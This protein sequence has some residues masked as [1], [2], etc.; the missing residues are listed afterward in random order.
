MDNQ[1]RLSLAPSDNINNITHPFATSRSLP[2]TNAQIASRTPI[3][4]EG[5]LSLY[6]EEL[7]DSIEKRLQENLDGYLF[8]PVEDAPGMYE[9]QQI[10]HI[11]QALYSEAA[12]RGL[13]PP[14][15]SQESLTTP[16]DRV[17]KGCWRTLRVLAYLNCTLEDLWVFAHHASG[18]YI[19]DRLPLASRKDSKDLWDIAPSADRKWLERKGS[20]G[21]R[22]YEAMFTMDPFIFQENQENVRPDRRTPIPII[23]REEIGQGS[24]ATVYECHIAKGGWQN[25]WSGNDRELNTAPKKLAQKVY[26]GWHKADRNSKLQKELEVFKRIK[27]APTT[28]KNVVSCLGSF[29]DEYD[30][31][32]FFEPAD[33]DNPSL[34]ILMQNAKGMERGSLKTFLKSAAGLAA[35][36]DYLHCH[37]EV[38]GLSIRIYHND[39]RPVNIL[40]F[41]DEWKVAD[42]GLSKIK[43]IGN[44]NASPAVHG[45]AVNAKGGSSDYESP[46]GTL[47]TD[48]DNWSLACILV[49]AITYKLDGPDGIEEFWEARQKHGEGKFWTEG[50]HQTREL[51]PAVADWVQQLK[52]RAR[53]WDQEICDAVSAILEYI[54]REVLVIDRSKRNGTAKSMSVELYKAADLL[55]DSEP[56]RPYKGDDMGSLTESRGSVDPTARASDQF[57]RLSTEYSGQQPEITRSRGWFSASRTS[58]RGQ[59]KFGA[60][61]AVETGNDSSVSGSRHSR[62]SS[63]SRYSGIFSSPVEPTTP[64]PRP[65]SESGE[66]SR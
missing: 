4:P 64:S 35:G 47:S 48:S 44:S 58:R 63:K 3:Y 7:C 40:I 66:P 24:S 38:D 33:R 18:L 34:E 9:E 55:K 59:P 29:E 2:R 16:V 37:I 32:L 13:A 36:L 60:N 65:A 1:P 19:D 10:R 12:R 43:E 6:V 61:L 45:S 20:L 5:S 8:L 62:N 28:H 53:A 23:H 30:V 21:S 41:G 49:V 39:F 42:L 14:V 52:T 22:F 51:N 17:F 57:S 11:I 50:V 46:D 54:L 26:K 15:A 31:S 27:A 56:A 25:G